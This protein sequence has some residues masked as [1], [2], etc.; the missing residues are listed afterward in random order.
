MDVGIDPLRRETH[1]LEGNPK[2]PNHTL[3]ADQA[4]NTCVVALA[5]DAYD[6]TDHEQAIYYQQ[7][8]SPPRTHSDFP[9]QGAA[10][11]SLTD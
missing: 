11:L 9:L 1:T 3:F 10:R 4:S 2:T 6:G 8:V 5:R 7:Y